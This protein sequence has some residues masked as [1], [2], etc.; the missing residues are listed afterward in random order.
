MTEQGKI[1]EGE[2]TKQTWVGDTAMTLGV[3][4]FDATHHVLNMALEDIHGLVDHDYSSDG[5][6]QSHVEW[7]GPFEVS[8]VESITGFFG[9]EDLQEITEDML[10]EARSRLP[11]QTDSS[12]TEPSTGHLAEAA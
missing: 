6:G 9:I 2:F 12:T 1:I 4:T 3:E 11:L 10:Q 5:I 8:I 7:D